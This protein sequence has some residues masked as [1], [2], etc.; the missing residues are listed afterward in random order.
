MPALDETKQMCHYLINLDIDKVALCGE[1]ANSRADILL[2][3]R[4]ENTKM[5]KTFEELLTA[6]KPE[7]VELVKS[8]ITATTK[9]KDDTIV[10]LNDTIEKAKKV[11]PVAPVVTAKEDDVFK[12]ASPEM[13]Q[14]VKSLQESVNTLVSA[15]ADTLAKARFE[16]V[17][18][19]PVDEAQ[20]K[21]ILKTAS[22]A[23]Y[24]V[25]EKAATA[26]EAKV[27]TVKGK[28]VPGA[29]FTGADSAYDALEKSA[30]TIQGINK[31]L[32]F[33]Q[34]FTQ[35]CNDSPETYAK[36]VKEAQ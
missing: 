4:K 6:L 5:A 19:I 35:A 8:H 18:A 34:A 17:K 1:G 11:P 2:T 22:P 31:S 24:A 3:K 14:Y 9:E 23:V 27:L 10:A 7:D 16:K 30:K 21:D 13:V 33:E 12:G 36:Y 28:E 26:I 25:L 29:E 32:S 15:Q 20:L